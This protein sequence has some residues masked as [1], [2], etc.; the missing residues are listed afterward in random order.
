M[1]LK[2]NLKRKI[3]ENMLTA[4][5]LAQ[6]SGVSIQSINNYKMGYCYPG[7]REL[8]RIARALGCTMDE[9]MEGEE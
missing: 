6:I 1:G 2:K 7:S 8:H 9:L 3:K 4:S 5:G